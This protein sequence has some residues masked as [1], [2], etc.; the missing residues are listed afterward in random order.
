MPRIKSGYSLREKRAL[1]QLFA[2]ALLGFLLFPITGIQAQV[3]P[4][5]GASGDLWADVVLGQTDFGGTNLHATNQSLFRAMGVY[6]DTN[7]NP[8]RLYVYDSGNNRI[9]GFSDINIAITRQGGQLGIDLCLGADSQALPMGADMVL[10]QPDFNHTAGNG[11]S[12]Y[13]QY[14]NTPQNL[15]FYVPTPTAQTLCLAGWNYANSLGEGGTAGTMATDSKGDLYVTD[16]SNNRVVRYENSS[17]VPGAQNVSASYVWGQPDAFS[18]KANQGLGG[19]TSFTL[20]FLAGGGPGAA[21][22]AVDPWNNLWVA[23]CGN[24]RVLRFPNNG[25]APTT[26]GADVFLGQVD[27]SSTTTT[28][29]IGPGSVR[30]DY[31]GDVFVYDNTSSSSSSNS[32]IL[33]FENHGTGMSSP[34]SSDYNPVTADLIIPIVPGNTKGIE[35]DPTVSHPYVGLWVNNTNS[36]AVQYLFNVSG[37]PV[38]YGPNKYLLV[39]SEWGNHRSRQLSPDGFQLFI[40]AREYGQNGLFNGWQ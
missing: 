34:A 19:P 8:Q 18:C 36:N 22:V 15:L 7:S 23:D 10:G 30:V 6:V 3:T 39:A 37:N 14:P 13:Q 27:S 21:G 28:T 38:T 4:V 12:N 17:L 40:S 20:S 2:F 32:R 31:K 16:Y 35:I 11:D 1:S 9:L 33:L 25:V 26:L 5:R 24:N 29:M